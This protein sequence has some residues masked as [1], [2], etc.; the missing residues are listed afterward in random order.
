MFGTVRTLLDNPELVADTWLNLASAIFFF[1]YP[2]PPKPSMLFVVDETWQPNSA[3]LAN[4]LTVGFGVTTQIING[5]VECVGSVEIAQS[6]NRIS[7][8]QSF[9]QHLGV[10]I[11]A[12][13][14]LGCAGMK[15]FDN[16]GSGALPIYWEKDWSWSE[17]T[18]SGDSL[19]CQLVNY[20]TPFTAFTSGDYVRCVDHHFDVDILPSLQ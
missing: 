16:A 9:A 11:G 13:E 5:G 2:Q 18:H 6:L 15:Q 19:A 12:D 7:Y 20:Q 3:D 10:A 14:Q 4:N 1:V 17:D 8:Y